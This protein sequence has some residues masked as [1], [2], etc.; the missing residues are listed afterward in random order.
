VL[1]C[2]C[3]GYSG[4]AGTSTSMRMIDAGRTVNDQPRLLTR[5][6]RPAAGPADGP[7]VPGRRFSTGPGPA[8]W[9]RAGGTRRRRSR[10]AAV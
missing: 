1:I 4:S 7:V 10:R 6:E 2:R 3:R 9:S 8:T 5:T